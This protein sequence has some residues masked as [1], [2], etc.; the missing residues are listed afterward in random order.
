MPSILST[1]FLI[2]VHL[3][4]TKKTKLGTH[5]NSQCAVFGCNN[6]PKRAICKGNSC[7][8]FRFP[9]EEGV[10][11]MWQFAPKRFSTNSCRGG[12]FRATKSSRIC[13]CH[14]LS[15]DYRLITSADGKTMERKLQKN[16]VTTRSIPKATTVHDEVPINF[17][18]VEDLQAWFSNSV[19][20]ERPY[21]HVYEP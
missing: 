6:T 2:G 7:S 5:Y 16:A 17:E 21:H 20:K 8:L 13:H 15:D 3:Q 1:D 11:K 19:E 10:K 9:S 4:F 14:F 18:D 12:S